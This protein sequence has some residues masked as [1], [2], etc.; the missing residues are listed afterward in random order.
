[1][2]HKQDINHDNIEL[3]N[4]GD[5]NKCA[6]S[7]AYANV[8]QAPSQVSVSNYNNQI[9]EN[10][11][12]LKF[13]KSKSRYMDEDKMDDMGKHVSQSRV[14]RYGG[15]YAMQRQQ[16]L[17]D[18]NKDKEINKE[19]QFIIGDKENFQTEKPLVQKDD[20]KKFDGK[21]KENGLGDHP[22]QTWTHERLFDHFKNNKEKGFSSAEADK[23]REIHGLN[24]ITPKKQRS[25]LMK[26]LINMLGGFQI[27]LWVGGFLC[28]IVY[29]ITNFHDYQTLTLGIICF[30]VVIGT[31][32]FQTYQEGKSTDVMAALRALT[33][34]K[35]MALRDGVMTEIDAVL[36]VPG[37]IIELKK[38]DK[39]PA[40]LRVISGEKLKVNNASLTGENVDI[41]LH[42]EVD[43]KSLY[44]AKNI[45]R[46]GCNFTNGKG[47]G[48]VF[49]TGDN[50]F[51]GN[52]AKST[53]NIKRPDS[54][55][56]KELKRLV[57]IM[58]TIA[59]IIGVI[60]LILALTGGYSVVD[61][62]VFMI[63][64]I[65]ANVP[66]GLLP[67][68]TV[69]LTLT[70]QKMQRQGV[71]VTNLEI[72]ETLGATSVICS[73]KT[74]TLTCNRMTVSHLSYDDDI[75]GVNNRSPV[76]IE[77][78]EEYLQNR[79]LVNSRKID[80]EKQYNTNSNSFQQLLKVIILNTNAKF[81]S[82][83]DKNG[84]VLNRKTKDGDAS[85]AALIKFAQPI[86]DITEYRAD[87]DIVHE[88]PFN[89]N[90]KWMLKIIKSV[91]NP[92]ENQGRYTYL[93]K[94]APEKVLSFC[95]Y[96]YHNGEV[97]PIE[98]KYVNILKLNETLAEQGERVLG[99]AFKIAKNTYN[100][101]NF[102]YA[103]EVDARGEWN[104]DFEDFVF[105]GLSSLQ[106][107]PREGVKESI[108]KCKKAGIKVFMVTGD[109]PATAESISRQLGLITSKRNCKKKGENNQE[110]DESEESIVIPGPELNS[111]KNEDW[112]ELFKHNE[113]V[114]ARTMPQQ[115]QEIVNQLKRLNHIV[116]MTGDGVNDAPALKAAH[117]GIAMGSGAAVAKEAGQ[118]ILLNDDFTSIVQGV[119]EGRLIFE[120]L[121]KC[122]SYVLTSNIP[123][124]LPFLLFIIIKIPLAIETIMI[125]LIDVGTDIVPTVALAYEEEEDET[126]SIP[127]R[128]MDS[129]LVGFK[130]MFLSYGILGLFQSFAA[131]WAW[132][133]VYYDHG[134]TVTTLVNMGLQYRDDFDKMTDDRKVYF[135]NLCKNDLWYKQNM[136]TSNCQQD[137]KNHLVNLMAIGQTVFL[138]TIV[139][140]Q[141]IL[142]FV[143]K[144]SAE[145]IFS[146]RRLTNNKPIFWSIL[147]ELAT[148]LIL[149][150]VPGLNKAFYLT[151]VSPKYACTALWMLPVLLIFEEGRKFIIRRNPDG[152]V[153]KL[154]R[155]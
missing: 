111:Y 132:A 125:I 119:Q 139:W 147:S 109:Q 93:L 8:Q 33:P 12:N 123:E 137:Y 94:G 133:W 46:M 95:K 100:D 124:L 129:H 130:L 59:I 83:D 71:L 107:P 98:E 104:F 69:A 113:I 97:C 118:L 41:N 149:S 67:Q 79:G 134:F 126:M 60:F 136:P 74:G 48:I 6:S 63:G 78:E 91:K 138:M 85:E 18:E 148:I 64:I 21:E 61:A 103:E 143:R 30:V 31:S 82:D 152:C 122:I 114:F 35:V 50:T 73:D 155:F 110:E 153:A 13:G 89:S 145:S 20:L 57:F 102:E 131:F 25:W 62:I 88:I 34:D 92:Q 11:I 19:S 70:A 142:V 10:D 65:I 135:Q 146:W 154:T 66:E 54:C 77:L 128:Q 72:I 42:S 81:E 5:L 105:V 37:D 47:I 86:Y 121:K 96:Y 51:F 112:D 29:I 84:D 3:R 127:P 39:V 38:N 7:A 43:E 14:L 36:L 26:F 117:V 141:I 76:E 108:A 68:I 22:F 16:N 4:Q 45:A 2:S 44:E 1:M 87:Y 52:I 99:F 144:T 53:L 23:L 120:N 56:T 101:P 151:G 90:N 32:F 150:Y 140:T 17:M 27:F 106:D 28:V 49:S 40:D 24:R 75:F 9:G 58:G 116:A 15:S 80:I 55:L 115:K